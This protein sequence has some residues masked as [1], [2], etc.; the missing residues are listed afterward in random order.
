MKLSKIHIFFAVFLISII[1]VNAAA[2]AQS[3]SVLIVPFKIHAEKELLFLK[4]GIQDMLKS[5]LSREGEIMPLNKDIPGQYLETADNMDEKNAAL[6]G[7][8]LNADYVVYGS[9]TVFGK[10]ISTDAVFFNVKNNKAD[11]IF[12]KSGKDN[13]DVIKHINE[14]AARINDKISGTG[15][16]FPAAGLETK[17]QEDESRRH[18]DSLWKDTVKEDKKNKPPALINSGSLGTIWKSRRFKTQIKGLAAGDVDGDSQQEI[19]F[20]DNKD[21]NI[22][23]YSNKMF[24]KIG[25]IKG[26]MHDNLISVDIADINGNDKSEIFVTCLNKS[27]K[28][29]RSFVLEW[30]GTQF[31]HI[32]KSAGWYYRV[33]DI[34][35]RGPMLMG[36]KRGF[37][38][39]FIPGIDELKWSAGQYIPVTPQKLPSR[40]NV[41]SFNYGDIM[42]NGQ[43]AAIMFSETEYLRVLNT[44]GSK[45][46]ES[47]EPMSGGAVFLEYDSESSGSFGAEKEQERQYLPHRIL[48]ADINKDSKNEIIVGQ[49]TDSAGRFFSKLRLYKSGHIKCLGW[50]DFGLNI[51]WKTPE[52]SGYI[53]DYALTDID[54]DGRDELIFSVVKKISSV[55]GEAQSFI[56]FQEID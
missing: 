25:E 2:S 43:M 1:F 5:R 20:I 17:S 16:V 9:L 50:D 33:L 53:S 47:A 45:E 15:T 28:A 49:N 3:S 10:S 4:K 23:R 41:Y 8:E 36:Q 38:K 19:V 22:Y 48:I 18:P 29:L 6:L 11:I 21:V 42:N 24:T 12:N 34:P 30:N 13:G 40:T 35:G 32:I 56:A 52:V 37:N 39:N 51:K 7:A 27:N 14:F 31:E 26:D 54:S 44:D 55:L 46:W